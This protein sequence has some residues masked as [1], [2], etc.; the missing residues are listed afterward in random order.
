MSS[1]G[2]TF[3]IRPIGVIRAADGVFRIEIRE[4]YR[5]AMKH[6]GAFSHIHV[7]W[8][9]HE[10]DSEETRAVL[11]A[12]LPYAEGVTA[13]VFACR[14]PLQPNPILETVCFVIEADEEAGVILIP[15]ID[16]LDGSPVLDIKPYIPVSDR[17]RECWSA[18]WLAGWPEW[19]EDGGAFFAEHDIDLGD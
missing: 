13:G 9:A 12:E 14:S 5:P 10:A 2:E 17:V 6:V 11:Q 16:A 3:E 7:Y 15:W 4:P 8:W 19:M 1:K 18:E